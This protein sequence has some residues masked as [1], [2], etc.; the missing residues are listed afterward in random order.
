MNK[1]LVIPIIIYIVGLVL[2]FFSSL[3]LSFV[4]F[5]FSMV[6][7]VYIVWLRQKQGVVSAA[8]K[9]KRKLIIYSCCALIIAPIF[10]GILLALAR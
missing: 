1:V 3:Y 9:E 8:E 10:V 6:L 5:F 4:P 7:L 2:S